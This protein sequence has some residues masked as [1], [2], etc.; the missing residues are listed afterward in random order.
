M[1]RRTY[2][3]FAPSLRGVSSR[4]RISRER[5][6]DED[7]RQTEGNDGRRPVCRPAMVAPTDQWH[8]STDAR[9]STLTPVQV[10]AI[11]E[12][13]QTLAEWPTPV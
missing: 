12:S 9:S 8:V 10:L 6:L 2:R 11:L 3:L 5:E 7:V 4:R 13:R 1:L